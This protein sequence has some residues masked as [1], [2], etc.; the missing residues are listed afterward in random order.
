MCIFIWPRWCVEVLVAFS[1]EL[2][3][4][5]YSAVF[6]MCSVCFNQSNIHY[7]LN[8]DQ[9]LV[10]CLSSAESGPGNPRCIHWRDITMTTALQSAPAAGG[11]RPTSNRVTPLQTNV[12]GALLKPFG[13]L[14]SLYMIYSKFSA[15]DKKA[16]VQQ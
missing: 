4:I 3:F 9:Q 8:K 15:H 6:R 14:S 13:V 10:R 2:K 12:P 16:Y 7:H 1:K 5:I 11:Y